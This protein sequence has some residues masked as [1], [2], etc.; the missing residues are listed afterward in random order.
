MG[1]SNIS[2]Y[3]LFSPARLGILVVNAVCFGACITLLG[4]GASG[5]PLI[6]L[7]IG[8]GLTFFSY[9]SG[10]LIASRNKRKL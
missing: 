10:A 9:L 2:L 5:G 8:T 1:K 6:L 3:Y 4:T 7:T